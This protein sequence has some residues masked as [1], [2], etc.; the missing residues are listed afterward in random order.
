MDQ[1]DFPKTKAVQPK[2]ATVQSQIPFVYK[3]LCVWTMDVQPMRACSPR[4]V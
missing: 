4:I 3:E 1:D 2:K